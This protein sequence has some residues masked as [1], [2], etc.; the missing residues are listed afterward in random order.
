MID[1]TT[2]QLA[3]RARVN[4]ET[5]RYYERN[6]LVEEPP[7]SAS[8]Y[9]K[10]PAD[11]VERLRFIKRAQSLGFSLQE[12]KEL[13][14]LRMRPDADCADIRR[15]AQAKL[16]DVD[17]RLR[18]LRALRASLVQLTHDCAGSGPVSNCSIL[19]SLG[20]EERT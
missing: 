11:S 18:E 20:E 1:F 19:Q 7:R 15:R 5:I 12:I 16:E 17:R 2:G 3:S 10:Y 4:V 14:E 8:G 6:G 13:L 9:R